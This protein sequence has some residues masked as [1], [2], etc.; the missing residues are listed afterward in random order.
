MG[1]LGTL[2]VFVQADALFA[3]PAFAEDPDSRAGPALGRGAGWG[4]LLRWWRLV[5]HPDAVIG[6]C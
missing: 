2:A 1:K 6:P 5:F 3:H 4:P